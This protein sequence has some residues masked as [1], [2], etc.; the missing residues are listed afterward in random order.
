MADFLSQLS[1]QQII[2][3]AK[4]GYD[5][6]MSNRLT[7]QLTIKQAAGQYYNRTSGMAMAQPLALSF[8][9]GRTLLPNLV[10]TFP[11]HII[12]TQFLAARQFAE[13]LGSVLSFQDRQLKIDD[14]YRCVITDALHSLGI[15]KTG[16]AA[17]GSIIQLLHQD[18]REEMVDTGEVYSE[19]VSFFNFVAD[20]DSRE[21]LFKDAR[22]MGDIIRVPRQALL[23]DKNYDHD[24]VVE[25]VNPDTSAKTAGASQ[26]SMTTTDRAENDSLEDIVEIC[27]LYVPSANAIVTIPGNFSKGEKFLRVTDYYGLKDVTGPYTF[28][29]LTVPVPDNPLPTPFFSVLIDL[30]MAAN[31]TQTLIMQQAE[32]QKDITL[33]SPDAADEAALLRDA[34]DG[35]MIASSDPNNIQ[36]RSFGGQHPPNEEHLNFLLNQ[37]NMLAANVESLSGVNSAAKSATAA[38]ILNQNAS[39][40]LGDMQNAVYKMAAE[41]ARKRAWYIFNDPYLNKTVARRQMDGGQLQM[42]PTGPQWVV[43][44]TIKDVQVTLTPDARQ[45]DFLDLVFTV[46]PES[47][48]RIDSKSRLQNTMQF[49]QQIL[50]ATA[51]AA[52]IFQGLGVP[53]DPVAF[54]MRIAKEMNIS[55][56]DEAVYAPAVQQKAAMEY[57]KIQQATGQDVPPGEQQPPNPGLNAAVMQNGQPGQVQAP[58][59]PPQMQQQQAAQ[60]GAQDSQRLIKTALAHSLNPPRPGNILPTQTV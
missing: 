10:M 13:D 23:D 57:N 25:L 1:P 47:M 46:E 48:T 60:A 7:A 11:R 52:Q 38:N 30:E 18:G 20:P 28:L 49:A 6:F 31:R 56:L 34:A 17:G 2:D 36:V 32:R 33:Y 37:F 9:A 27:E 40:G 55:W 5:R 41:E 51:G 43:P 53:F 45:G 16:I 50:P 58:P 22:F 4:R 21:Y 29:S 8:N 14:L 3:S 35:D 39:V 59:P 42:T 24:A 15:I 26:L 12:E 19:R 44:P 54:L